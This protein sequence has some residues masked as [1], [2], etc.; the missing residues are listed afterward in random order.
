MLFEEK[1]C[2]VLLAV[3]VLLIFSQAVVRNCPPLSRM[4]I[5]A[6]LAHATEVLPSGLTWLTFLACGAVTRRKDL[7]RVDLISNRL[8]PKNRRRLEG[9]IWI[10]W[11]LFFVVL[12]VLGSAATYRLR[13]QMTSLA[14]L[15]AWAVALSVPLGA[16]LVIW[17]TLQNLFEMKTREGGN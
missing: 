5:A 2:A 4:A 13:G 12:L 3:M 11:G 17:R 6:W 10:L 16:A 9:V 14:W 1:V 7:L 8:S 15:P